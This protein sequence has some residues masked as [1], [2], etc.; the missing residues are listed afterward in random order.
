[1]TSNDEKSKN[2]DELRPAFVH[3]DPYLI[4]HDESAAHFEIRRTE[5]DERMFPLLFDR[6]GVAAGDFKE[7]ARALARAYVKGFQYRQPNPA[8]VRELAECRRIV[9]YVEKARREGAKSNGAAFEALI[10]SGAPYE[11][12]DGDIY[13][14]EKKYN[15]ALSYL[16]EAGY[17]PDREVL[18]A[19]CYQELKWSLIHQTCRI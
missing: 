16:I 17:N 18:K 3:I 12:P 13:S 19:D 8:N 4:G 7:L 1:M 15:R 11:N 6:H 9:G 2:L 10:G 5:E 14:I